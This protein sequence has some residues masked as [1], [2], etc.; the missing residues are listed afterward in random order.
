LIV[1]VIET[2]EL[3]DIDKHEECLKPFHKDFKVIVASICGHGDDG[4]HRLDE[5]VWRGRG[6]F[7]FDDP[8]HGIGYAAPD[9]MSK[10][11][12]AISAGRGASW[13]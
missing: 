5:G 7:S 9:P 13:W 11:A 6:G 12:I 2:N 10:V 8:T 3:V 1:I 4:G